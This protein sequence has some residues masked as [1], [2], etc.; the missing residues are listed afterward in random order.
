MLCR[1]L[2]G[3]N[4]SLP[5]SERAA[6]EQRQPN[7]RR[8]LDTKKQQQQ[9]HHQQQPNLYPNQAKMNPKSNLGTNTEPPSSWILSRRLHSSNCSEKSQ[10]E[11]CPSPNGQR[12]ARAGQSLSPPLPPVLAQL[13]KP[14]L[15]LQAPK[16]AWRERSPPG[17]GKKIQ[18]VVELL[19]GNLVTGKQKVF[20]FLPPPANQFVFKGFFLSIL[21]FFY[22]EMSLKQ[23][24]SWEFLWGSGSSSHVREKRKG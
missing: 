21:R 23:Q 19:V 7:S 3:V 8:H 12:W 22:V 1:A 4:L 5:L 15:D 10:G 18:R 9:Q 14:G 17:L 2:A 11:L 24:Q 6:S 16:P 13:L 20:S